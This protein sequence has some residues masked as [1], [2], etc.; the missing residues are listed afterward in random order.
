MWSK[1]YLCLNQR[2]PPL[3]PI[4]NLCLASLKLKMVSRLKFALPADWSLSGAKSGNAIGE[5]L[6]IALRSASQNDKAN[7]LHSL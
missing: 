4:L 5:T 6:S 7:P 1:I 2:H 3:L